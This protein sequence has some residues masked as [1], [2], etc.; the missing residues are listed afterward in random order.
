MNILRIYLIFL[1]S[2]FITFIF[3]FGA[4]AQQKY[5]LS[6]RRNV[7]STA[8]PFLMI[9]PDSRSGAMAD[10]GVAI[11]NDPN[12]IHWN[13]AKLAFATDDMG[14]SVSYVPW[15]RS[16][17]PDINLSYLSGYKRIDAMST[18]GAS[19]R[20]FSL[21]DI[22]FTNDKGEPLGSF[23]PNE[24]ALDGEYAR[25]LSEQF[26][27]GLG[28]RFIYSNLTGGTPVNGTTATNPG[29]AFAGDLSGFW[30]G[31]EFKMFHKVF[32]ANY[33]INFSNIG[34]KITY[35]DQTQRD[36]IPMN[37]RVGTYINCAIDQYNQ[38]AL[39]FD[40]NKLLVPTAPIYQSDSNGQGIYGPDGELLLLYGKNPDVPVIKGMFQSF[41][42]APG[43]LQ[44]EL[45]EI[46]PS[47]ALEYWYNK[48]FSLRA[49]YFYEHP[50][51]GN[52][53]YVTLGV[54]VKYSILNIDVSYLLPTSVKTANQSSPL[55]NTL[56]FTLIFNFASEK[57]KA[58][59]KK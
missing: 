11:P 58:K 27:L 32:N 23:R 26:S 33:G 47:V 14:L 52:R 45:R 24:L 18:F 4:N 13:C 41:T 39:A 44:E 9:T 21:G 38:I 7:V 46:N 53:Q 40:L 35:T 22:D 16:L 5:D 29:I 43:G 54:G 2:L 56:R 20:Y 12:A 59:K 37:L 1:L 50:T 6:G 3:P 17:V 34:S 49:G 51:K 42:D 28:L 8:V 19:L 57:D 55:Q 30:K 31:K 15:L 10:A 25:K 36:F 48:Q